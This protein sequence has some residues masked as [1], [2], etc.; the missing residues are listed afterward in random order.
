MGSRH[1][2]IPLSVRTIEFPP[3][4]AGRVESQDKFRF[5]VDGRQTLVFGRKAHSDLLNTDTDISPESAGQIQL[6]G[7]EMMYLKWIQATW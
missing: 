1:W 3:S 5:V 4:A 2:E 6:H 7:N